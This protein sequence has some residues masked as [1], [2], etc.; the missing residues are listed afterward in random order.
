MSL[1]FQPFQIG[2]LRLR[3]RFVRSATHD[4]LGQPDGTVSE[5]QVAL[6][7]ELAE[8]GVGLIISGHAYVEHPLGRASVNQNAVYADRFVPGLRRL[9]DAAH[10]GGAA[11]V[12]QVS[13]AGRQTPQDWPAG[14]V[15]VAPSAVPEVGASL[16]PRE[17]TEAEIW[18]LVESFAQAMGRARAAGCDGVQLH[19]AHGYLLAAF[20]SPYTNRRTDGW[21]GSPEGRCRILGEILA[22]GRK[23]VGPD[24]PVLVKLN[25]TD[26]G[27][28]AGRLS[29]AEAVDAA[30]ALVAWGVDA[31]EVSGGQRENRSVMS[32]PAILAPE[33][34]AYF[35]DAARAIK[36]AVDVPVILVG[37]LRSRAVMEAVVSSGTADLVALSRPLVL[38]PD[39]VNRLQAGQ[40]QAA[41]VSC[42][43]CFDPA[44][45]ACRKPEGL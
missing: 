42:N 44:G 7:R 23:A 45:L 37:G 35:A 34:E 8:G 29:L 43:A 12:L 19:L 10:A 9:A 28:G 30:R 31:V 39:L 17:L 32:R 26:G 11:L 21:G 1:L 20:L 38:E 40:P 3:N 27:S 13:H 36:A 24:F 25:T 22:R 16:C 15:P 2:R 6:Y 5:R 18:S 33:Q 4:Y 14:L 41:C